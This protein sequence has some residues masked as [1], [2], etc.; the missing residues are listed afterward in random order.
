MSELRFGGYRVVETLGSGA[1]CSLYKAV[2]ESTGR[3]VVIKA[4]KSTI[5]PGSP[6]AAQID[7]EAAALSELAHPGVVMLFDCVRGA[8]SYLVLEHI[9][10]WPLRALLGKSKSLRT[11]VAASIA[12]EVLSALDHVH[13]RGFVHRD[14]KP[15]NVM[16]GPRGDVKLIDFGIAQR[17]RGAGEVVALDGHGAVAATEAFGTPAYMSPEQILG[18][19]VDGRSDL[20]SLGVMLYEALGGK[21]PHE[22]KD[23]AAARSGAL[24]RGNVVPLRA[25]APHVSHALE[26]VVLRLL[27]KAPRDRFATAAEAEAA[28]APHAA[29]TTE[30]RRSLVRRALRDAGLLKDKGRDPARPAAQTRSVAPLLVTTGGFAALLAVFA[31]GVGLNEAFSA[32]RPSR[33]AAADIALPLAPRDGGGLRVL[34]S[35]WAEVRVDGQYV[36]TT[37]FA[38]PIPL[39]PGT[40]WVSLA[41]PSAPEERREVHIQPG[42]TLTLEVA[43]SLD[44][45]E[46]RP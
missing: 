14:V 38:R 46:A 19:S 28:L 35:P 20:F 16:L 3:T 36:D 40:H 37:P 45:E 21:L 26:A 31:G 23:E 7:R 17:T 30:E 42:E 24:R 15:A 1:V 11:D 32:P 33:T 13:R 8:R 25:R 9:E 27:E 10:G 44:P 12:C 4:L 22:A 6:L 18:D 39:S 41:H 2:Q 34:A 43:M 29:A 5:L